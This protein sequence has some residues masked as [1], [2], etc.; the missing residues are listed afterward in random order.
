MDEPLSNSPKNNK[1]SCWLLMGIL[2]LENLVSLEWYVFVC[3]LLFVL[4]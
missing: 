3:V 2:R 4:C 1:A